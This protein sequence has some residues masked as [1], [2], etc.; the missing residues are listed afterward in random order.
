MD[1]IDQDQ[2]R[3]VQQ[4]AEQQRHWLPFAVAPNFPAA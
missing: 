4:A 2:R 3:C 1:R